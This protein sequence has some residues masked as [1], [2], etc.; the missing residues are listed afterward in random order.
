MK[1]RIAFVA[2]VFIGFFLL[3]SRCPAPLVYRPGEG[4]TYES[5]GGG[6]WVRGRA[7]DQY[8]VAQQAFDQKDFGTTKKAARRVV[9]RWPLSDYA[10]QAQYLLARCYEARRDDGRAF[11]EYQKLVEKYPKADNFDEVLRRQYEIADR[12]L[13]GQRFKLWGLFP[14][15]R[16]MEK[17][18]DMFM[19]I[20]RN[21]PF[22]PI[23]PEAQMK[24]GAA[25]EK[26]KEYGLAVK[27]YERAANVYHDNPKI[28]AEATFRAGLAYQKQAQTAE[29][30]QSA[31]ADA[32]ST[33]TDFNVLYP[34]EARVA[35][36]K[37]IIAELQ[38]EQARGAY[39]IA[40]FYDKKRKWDGAKVY[41]NEV[42]SKDPD[43]SYAAE[44]RKRLE[45][46]ARIT[47]R[48]KTPAPAGP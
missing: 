40:Q 20:N 4:W 42:V 2:V 7:K 37:Q 3:P 14:L 26:Q 32:I 29:Y 33:F 45:A 35:Q 44:A 47:A 11:K 36:A 13:A 38:T 31:A 30:D 6:K 48:S 8:D 9:K 41:Y 18:A 34:D 39:R 25:R 21:G 1:R 10:P 28:A 22:S 12:F 43:S 46:I 23:A 15:F 27:A 5:V 16:S 19:K 24:V 17:T